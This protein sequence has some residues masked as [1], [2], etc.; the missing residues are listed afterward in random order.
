MIPQNHRTLVNRGLAVLLTLAALCLSMVTAPAPSHAAPSAGEVAAAEARLHELERDFEIVSEEYNLVHEKLDDLRARIGAAELVV[1][2]IRSRMDNKEEAAVDL[3]T[4]LYMAGGSSGAIEAVLTSDNFADV[5]ERLQYLKTSE[6]EQAKVFDRLAADNAL[7]DSK[8][9]SL[10][11]ATAEAAQ[12]EQRLAELR[13]SIDD[14]VQSQQG[15]IARLNELIAEAVARREA[16]EEAAAEEAAAAAAAAAAQEAAAPSS[17]G[18]G[19][20]PVIAS[21]PAPNGSAQTAVDAALSQVGKPYQW[22]ASGP[23]SYDCSGLTMWAWAQAGV[24]LPHNSGAQYAATPRVA[25]G[26]WQPGDLLFYGSPI[27]HVA[28]YIGNGQMVEAPY[29]G[30]SVRVVSAYRSDYVGAGRPGV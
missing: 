24:S 21:A 4:E 18:S 6:S 20:A 27:H 12:E 17:G 5:E 9:E 30:L 2:K 7:L 10:Q 11:D 25:Q 22:G 28:M 14:K 13:S 3:A 26:D 16:A 15:E 1:E 19:P 29:T 8:I 23:D